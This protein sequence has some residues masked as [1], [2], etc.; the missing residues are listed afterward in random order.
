M[1]GCCMWLHWAAQE[2][3]KYTSSPMCCELQHSTP[4]MVP[5]RHD[6][7]LYLAF[8]N[9]FCPPFC[10][11]FSNWFGCSGQH[12][13]LT[14]T[15]SWTGLNWCQARL[16]L[17]ACT[18]RRTMALCATWRRIPTLWA[19]STP[20]RCARLHFSFWGNNIED[21]LPFKCPADTVGLLNTQQVQL[22]HS[23]S[24]ISY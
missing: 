14:R 4:S 23:D 15:H 13:R 6:A 5:P 3:D 11:L 9:L 20:S 7:M 16:L 24:R 19:C 2:A 18:T 22:W 12:R 1:S 17:A 21:S 10:L 8:W